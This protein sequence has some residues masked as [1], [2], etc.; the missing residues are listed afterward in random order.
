MTTIL[1]DAQDDER[2][3]AV[4]EAA[5]AWTRATGGHLHC[6]QVSPYEAYVTSGGFGD[7]YGLGQLTKAIDERGEAFE[8]E[9]REELG[10]EDVSWDYNRQTGHAI[11]AIV[12]RAAM[13]DLLVTSR[14]VHRAIG[15]SSAL[16]RLG[17]I[18]TRSRTPVFI[19][20]DDDHH[21]DPKGTAVIAWDGSY[22]IANTVRTSVPFLRLASDVK[23]VTVEEKEE[24]FPGTE[25]L[26]YLSRHDVH[27]ELH[28]EPFDEDEVETVLLGHARLSENP[29]LVVGAY[30]HSRV[31]EY[32]FGGV[33]RSLLKS[34][35]VGL[36]MSH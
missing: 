12:H 19:P 29:Y 4:T 8:K 23:V 7:L 3:Q 21:V 31:G 2:I 5:L 32:L 30:S 17:E 25:L 35:P 9:L 14:H 34:C 18:L 28:V 16:A 15:W 27:A 6:L 36:V 22:E 10:N 11:T 20:G 26:K 33:T 24:E 1:L 13:A